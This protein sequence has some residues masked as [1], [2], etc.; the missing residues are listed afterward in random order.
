MRYTKTVRPGTEH[1]PEAEGKARLFSNAE[2]QIS[3]QT[4]EPGLLGQPRPQRSCSTKLGSQMGTRVRRVWCCARA[5]PGSWQGSAA[6][7]LGEKRDFPQ[8]GPR[9]SCKLRC[10]ST[11]WHSGHFCP[12]PRAPVALRTHLSAYSVPSSGHRNPIRSQLEQKN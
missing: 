1:L 10:F 2:A 4:H 12:C 5:S 7:P 9:L 11:D 8:S 3:C 6:N